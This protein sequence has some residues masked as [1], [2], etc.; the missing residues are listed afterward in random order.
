MVEVGEVKNIVMVLWLCC[1]ADYCVDGVLTR[2][3]APR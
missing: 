3:D 1:G 2:A